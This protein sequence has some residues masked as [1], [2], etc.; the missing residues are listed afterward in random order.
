MA[1]DII[2]SIEWKVIKGKEADIEDK[3][4]TEIADGWTP[5]GIAVSDKTLIVSL[6]RA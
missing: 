1:V 5:Q 6:I 4:K 2:P 3:V